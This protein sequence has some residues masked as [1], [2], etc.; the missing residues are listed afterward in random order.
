MH[1]QDLDLE[2]DFS[3]SAQLEGQ[4]STAIGTASQRRRLS[5]AQAPASSKNHQFQECGAASL[6]RPK[7][8]LIG[9][10][11]TERG[12]DVNQGGWVQKLQW[13]YNRKVRSSYGQYREEFCKNKAKVTPTLFVARQGTC[14]DALS[15]V[16]LALLCSHGRSLKG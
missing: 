15:S 14:Q 6:V 1:A 12:L 13:W 5:A 2:A 7:I 11:H 10:S 9:D 8:L 3:P 16:L 4:N